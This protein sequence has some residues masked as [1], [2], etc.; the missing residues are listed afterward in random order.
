MDLLNPLDRKRLGTN[1][2]M[3]FITDRGRKALE[4]WIK[5]LEIRKKRISTIISE[6]AQQKGRA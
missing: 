1:R 4:D 3:Y 2:R 5:F 6:Y